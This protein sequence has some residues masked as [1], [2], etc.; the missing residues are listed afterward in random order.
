MLW[1]G[2]HDFSEE[3]EREREREREGGGGGGEEVSAS[4]R[5]SWCSW[6]FSELEN[7]RFVWG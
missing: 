4:G 3:R 1:G 5:C 7:L 6:M 2:Y